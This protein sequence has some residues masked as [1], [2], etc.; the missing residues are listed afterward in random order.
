MAKKFHLFDTPALVGKFDTD[1]LVT[2]LCGKS[3]K[4][5][6]KRHDALREAGSP[7]VCLDCV[8][9]HAAMVSTGQA[10]PLG[11]SLP[12]SAL[13]SGATL[14]PTQYYRVEFRAVPESKSK[15]DFP[16]GS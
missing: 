11:D 12:A 10:K 6:S 15:W 9:I 7:P 14:P 1:E 4:V 3:K 16:L 8:K 13:N 2:A 5:K